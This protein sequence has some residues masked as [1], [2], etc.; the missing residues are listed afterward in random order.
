MA[1]NFLPIPSKQATP[2]PELS[3]HLLDYISSHFRDAHPE[4]FKRDV[5]SLVGMR[6]EWVE[7]KSEA[8]PE[9]ARGLMKYHAQLAFAATKFPSDI[10]QQFTYSLPFPPPYSL[11][12][13]APISLPSLTYER[14]GVL[15]NAAA[16]YASLA[17]F[18]RRA[19]AESIKRALG[20]LTVSDYYKSALAAAN[21][22]DFP[23]ASYLP[24]CHF[25]A[26]AQYRLSRDDNEKA[27]YGE[28]IGRLRVAETLAKKG[29]DAGRKGVSDNVMSD[30]K[31]LQG[32]VKSTLESADRDN[33]MIYCQAVPTPAQLP[34]INGVGMV[35]LQTPTE[36]AEPIAWLMSGGSGSAPLFSG[37]VPYGVH[38]ALS[39]YD[40]RKDTLI[41]DMDGKREELDGIAASTLQSLNLPGSLQ[42]LERPVGL[43]P[44]LLKK[45]EEVDAAGGADKIRSL[46]MDV[47]RLSKSNAKILSEEAHETEQL[48]ERQPHVAET[49]P[50]SHVAN[51]SLIQMAGQYDGTLKQAA[52]SDATDIISD[53]VP[54]TTSSGAGFSA[55]PASVRP[56]RASLE[57]LDDHIAHRA[58]L[59]SEARQIA[60]HDDVRP[61]VLQ[62]ASK[63]AHGG[64]GDVKP[65]WF[66]GI[67]EESLSRYDKLRD[68]MSDETS[69]QEQLLEQI[70][71][72][73]N[74]F[75]SERKEDP[76][77]KER[78][79]RLQDMDVAYWKWREIVDNAE[80]GIKF[81][82]SLADMLHGFKEACS[83]F[84]NARRV[85]VGHSPVAAKA[86]LSPPPQSPAPS[87]FAPTPVPAPV[88]A[89]EPAPF[90]AHPSSAQWTSADLL[91]P[92]PP[93]AI[94]SGG[95]RQA[96]ASAPAPDTPRRV[97]RSQKGPIGDPDV[98]PYKKG[99]R[100]G[101]EGVI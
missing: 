57:D 44:S 35:K 53:H 86:P 99:S 54:S 50:P 62:E 48:V 88:P 81:Y 64:S 83:Q 82:N 77:V 23:C 26:A 27:K 37:L 65:E 9:V 29:L 15:F 52:Q 58:A 72:Q 6:K 36:V 100:K 97:T 60:E 55:L 80:E 7:P 43:P 30:L 71:Q 61:Q 96:P 85:D 59:V 94:R 39:I 24:Q 14:A 32:V 49:R 19:E 2:L 95:V 40:D 67:F 93:P 63:L 91:P 3:Q 47:N 22:L 76:R 84:L 66:E 69:T 89:R 17:A 1:T 92:P 51:A 31:Q 4:A 45:A 10:G 5:G 16:I 28:E 34:P 46:L 68:S 41:R 56:L 13:D 42:A 8:H 38:L 73:N 74:A 18:E 98:N 20:Y 12:P 87:S 75:L 90:L 70:R 11:T 25:E 33:L 21:G 78:E 101:G 79:R